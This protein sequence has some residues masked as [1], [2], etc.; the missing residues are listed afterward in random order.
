MYTKL[1]NKPFTNIALNVT[2][3][4]FRVID[5]VVKAM[6]E[7]FFLI[8]DPTQIFISRIAFPEVNLT[9]NPIPGTSNA[10]C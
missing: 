10:R 9:C 7:R 4:I 8:P 5:F 6:K 2:V 1:S 3:L